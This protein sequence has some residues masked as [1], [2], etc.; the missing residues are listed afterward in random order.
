MG[1][2][3][4]TQ[5]QTFIKMDAHIQDKI[6]N[7]LLG[8][9]SEEE[10]SAFEKEMEADQELKK[11]YIFTKN[12]KQE[13][14]ERAHLKEKMRKWDKER[15]RR[16]A[17]RPARK[18]MYAAASMAAVVLA[19]L[20]YLN[21]LTTTGEGDG[22]RQSNSSAF[23]EEVNV[24]VKNKDYETALE[25]IDAKIEENDNQ[26]SYNERYADGI[27]DVDEDENVPTP[28]EAREALKEA[29]ELQ[30]ELL[31]SKARVLMEM[32][33]KDEASAILEELADKDHSLQERAKGL[34]RQIKDQ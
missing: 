25:L 34:L 13:I 3:H 24:L 28:E 8:R 33:E 12:L 22:V 27:A 32:G 7:Y 6:D 20:F 4:H 10:R 31:L 14:D 11:Q 17:A 26:I 23:N 30:G 29:K 5:Y 1:P 2:V 21:I 16:A 19:G 18:W 9:M 15:E